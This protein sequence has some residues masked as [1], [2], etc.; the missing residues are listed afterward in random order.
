VVKFR[1]P[2]QNALAMQNKP[3]RNSTETTV[4]WGRG[5][6]KKTHE[7]NKKASNSE[8]PNAAPEG[9]ET[10]AKEPAHHAQERDKWPARKWD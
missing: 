4:A 10:Y 9:G 7:I 8:L 3:R 2:L 6:S 5:M 1:L